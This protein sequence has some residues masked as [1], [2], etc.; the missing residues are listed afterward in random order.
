MKF[1]Q[2]GA[3]SAILCNFMHS[4]DADL[5]KGMQL[6]HLEEIVLGLATLQ[7]I[8]LKLLVKAVFQEL[9][10][11]LLVPKAVVYFL[12]ADTDL[13]ILVLLKLVSR[14]YILFGIQ[15]GVRTVSNRKTR[16][17]DGKRKC[18]TVFQWGF[19]AKPLVFCSKLE[20]NNVSWSSK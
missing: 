6:I 10:L 8:L 14:N 15:M 4:S 2:S 11:W 3:S 18:V 19:T 9:A 7:A 20:L 12:S 1:A 5:Q 13:R 16:L 17:E